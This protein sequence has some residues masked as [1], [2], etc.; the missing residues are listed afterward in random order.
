M[1]TTFNIFINETYLEGG[2]Q[3][4]FHI[5]HNLKQILESDVLKSTI[6]A[7]GDPSIC[8]TRSSTYDIDLDIINYRLVLDID[9]LKIDGYKFIPISEEMSMAKTKYGEND[10]G[11]GFHKNPRIIGK[12]KV[13]YTDRAPIHNINYG[14]G[15]RGDYLGSYNIEY[16]ERCPKSIENIGKYIIAIDVNVDKINDVKDDLKKYTEKYPHIKIVKL[17]DGKYWYRKDE[18]NIN[19][20]SKEKEILKRT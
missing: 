3:P 11:K 6:N 2:N 20:I 13:N 17:Y 5:T 15:Q 8:F 1:I 16:E 7:F 19:S 14:K 12:S 18:Y 10:K 4:L 9:K